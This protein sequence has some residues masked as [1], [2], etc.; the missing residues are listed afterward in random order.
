[1]GNVFQPAFR[2][3]YFPR[4]AINTTLTVEDISKFGNPICNTNTDSNH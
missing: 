3:S 4:K 2:F 1:M